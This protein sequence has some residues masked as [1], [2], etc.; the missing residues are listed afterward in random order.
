M[1]SDG[2]QIICYQL[3]ERGQ[4]ILLVLCGRKKMSKTVTSNYLED[5]VPNEVLIVKK[6]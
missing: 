3:L 5:N 1:P 4:F 2:R 6:N